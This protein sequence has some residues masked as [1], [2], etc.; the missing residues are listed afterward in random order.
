MA[1]S[2]AVVA[3]GAAVALVVT[4]AIAS[5][6]PARSPRSPSVAEAPSVETEGS[7]GG[8]RAEVA[9]STPA[10]ARSADAPMVIASADAPV[11]PT[12]VRLADVEERS[13]GASTAWLADAAGT[14]AVT[15][16][17]RFR[18]YVV[19][20]VQDGTERRPAVA[21]LRGTSGVCRTPTSFEQMV[22]TLAAIENEPP[23][24]PDRALAN[25]LAEVV[26]R[27]IPRAGNQP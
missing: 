11:C 23:R 22:G 2:K 14:E 10:R 5:R 15:I 24:L 3:V 12:S 25:Q 21:W 17:G 19:V 8:R 9:A 13:D 18:G 26:R 27:L 16:G 7:L 20:A 4:W 6:S 1:A